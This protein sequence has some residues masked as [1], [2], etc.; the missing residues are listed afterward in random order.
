MHAT[1][2]TRP[3]HDALLSEVLT[4][5]RPDELPP[6]RELVLCWIPKQAPFAVHAHVAEGFHDPAFGGWHILGVDL[7]THE[8][9]TIAGWATY[10]KGPR[11]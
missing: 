11:A 8:T 3:H 6:A 7:G 5:N 2:P 4:W 10:P 1:A 9:P